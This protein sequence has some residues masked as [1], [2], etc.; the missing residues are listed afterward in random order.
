[1]FWFYRTDFSSLGSNH[2][3]SGPNLS[4]IS[5]NSTHAITINRFT[6]SNKLSF[7]LI[8]LYRPHS[9]FSSDSLTKVMHFPCLT[10]RLFPPLFLFVLITLMDPIFIDMVK[11]LTTNFS[12]FSCYFLLLSR[13]SPQHP[14]LR[15]LDSLQTNRQNYAFFKSLDA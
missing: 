10:Y 11:F 15:Q 6:F 9:L 3:D 2:H 8:C 5:T 14:V 1:M 12:L 4:Q 13:Q 7:S